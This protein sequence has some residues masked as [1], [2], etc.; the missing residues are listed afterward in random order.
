MSVR[1]LSSAN[2]PEST[3]TVVPPDKRA[4]AQQIFDLVALQWRDDLGRHCRDGRI[5]YSHYDWNTSRVGVIGDNIVT[6]YGVYDTTI[7]VG[8][9]RVRAAGVNL[10]V[11]HPDHRK[12]GLM[13]KTI[14]ASIE[15]MRSRGYDI[16]IVANAVESYYERFGYVV[17]WPEVHYFVRTEDLPTER[18]TARLRTFNTRHRPIMADL[19]NAENANVTG[20]AV[21]PTF[22]R[23]KE[24]GDLQGYLMLD[25]QSNITGYIIYDVVS[26]GSAVWHYDSAGDPEERLRIFGQIARRLDA[27]EVRFNRLPFSTTL[28]SRLRLRSCYSESKYVQSGGWMIQIINLRTLFEKLAAELSARLARSSMARWS[29]DLR[30]ST[31]NESI[32]LTIE[33][34]H[35]TVGPSMDSEHSI[36]GGEEIALLVMGTEAPHETTTAAATRLTGDAAC[37]IEVLF[38][39]QSPQMGNA[40]L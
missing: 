26:R 23:T 12:Q 16:S 29:G 34:G 35:I 32:T 37:L 33:S 40:D 31:R 15:A 5:N 9:S 27:E 11:T 36:E 2:R 18:P 24:P 38:P 17:A 8:S 25:H 13:P 39:S 10:V 6:H 30:I 7:R 19:Y 20:T 3:F 21:R 4:H 22:L 28:A 14:W 1:P